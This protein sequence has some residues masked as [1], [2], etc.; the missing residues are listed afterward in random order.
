MNANWKLG[1]AVLTGSLAAA[2]F[3]APAA[4]AAPAGMKT[5]TYQGRHFTVPVSWPVLDLTANPSTCVRFDRPAVYLGT[6]GAEQNCP[7]GLRGRTEALLVEPATTASGAAV[8]TENSTGHEFTSTASGIK[9]TVSYGA[10]RAAA[11]AIL[12]SAALP[13]TGRAAPPAPA[14]AAPRTATTVSPMFS[15]TVTNYTGQGFDPC[16]APGS[17]A[18]SAWRSASP[19]GAVGIYIGGSNRACAQPNLT[20]GWVAQPALACWVIQLAVRFGWAQA[21]LPPPM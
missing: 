15:G 6:P 13:T 21:R 14:P 18:M 16:A 19:Y 7:A 8:T 3:A 12:A 17:A 2:T 20:A 11:T 9:V 1:L 5:V 4:S 10:D